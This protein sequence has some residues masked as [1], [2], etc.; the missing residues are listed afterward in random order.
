[1]VIENTGNVNDTYNLTTGFVLEGWTVIFSQD[2]ITLGRGEVGR[3]IMTVI[4]S[5]TAAESSMA[6][7]NVYATSSFV[8]DVKN[9]TET[10]TIIK[11]NAAI[12]IT[13]SPSEQAV[14]A[15][16]IAS[17]Q[18]NIT[19]L[20]PSPLQVT[21]STNP[22]PQGWSSWLSAYSLS[23]GSYNRT[24][25]YLFVQTPATNVSA[26][27]RMTSVVRAVAIT[28]DS[29][30]SNLTRATTIIAQLH[31]MD[32]IEP[33]SS[34]EAKP[35]DTLEFLLRFVNN[36]NANDTLTFNIPY[37]FWNAS[38]SRP[39]LTLEV[40]ESGSVLLTA[41]V[42]STE[43][44][45]Q[46]MLVLESSSPGQKIYT[47][48]TINVSKVSN[49]VFKN[50]SPVI[51][52][53]PA[54]IHYEIPVQNRGNGLEELSLI[55]G[56]PAT[57][58]W[59]ILHGTKLPPIDI[60]G[61]F[62]LSYNISIPANAQAGRYAFT[63]MLKNQEGDS[64]GEIRSIIDVA[65]PDIQLDASYSPSVFSVGD[66]LTFPLTLK[67][68]GLVDAYNLTIAL[69]RDGKVFDKT[70]IS[71]IPAGDT[72]TAIFYYRAEKARFNVEIMADPSNTISETNE[73]NNNVVFIM[74]ASSS[75][76]VLES[77][78]FELCVMIPFLLFAGVVIV[79]MLVYQQ[80]KKKK[81]T[82]SMWQ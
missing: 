79:V 37:R 78:T 73:N 72:R 60:N 64:L 65:D 45:G 42:P 75:P 34:K 52:S 50:P 35:G 23:L 74:E 63:M 29:Y 51:T 54:V 41:E 16:E 81:E 55:I 7:I 11:A 9:K 14:L 80:I 67:N 49:L 18:V 82:E 38:I 36:G 26:N 62:N 24:S 43:R 3:V 61:S 12:N 47:N 1:L 59:V 40:G 15:G 46:Y 44:A 69:V 77:Y 56:P 71:H 31:Q 48:I 17:Y 28:S 4:P 19:N 13:V 27:E 70:T 5:P 32:L 58:S 66:D 2:N 8:P 22:L 53:R 68:T 10:I 33:P 76:S 20:G 30:A 6:I 57:A 21:L 25:I 39:N